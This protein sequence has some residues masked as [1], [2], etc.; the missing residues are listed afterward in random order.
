MAKG[1]SRRRFMKTVMAG[2]GAVLLAPTRRAFPA[3]G[4]KT[5]MT[6]A[7]PFG[8]TSLAFQEDLAKRFMERQKS[9]EIEVQIIPQV[10]AVPKL[11]AAFA[12]GAAP[13]CL[14][15]S[16][17]WLTQLAPPGYFESLEPQLK[18]SGLDRDI[19][20][21]GRVFVT[22]YVFDKEMIYAKRLLNPVQLE[23][24]ER[25]YRPFAQKV[26]TPAVVV[27]LQD[28]PA[29]CLDRIHRRSRPYEQEIALEFLEALDEDYRRMFAGWK[30]CPVIRIP[31]SRLTGYADAVVEHMVLQVKA[32][33]ATEAESSRGV[34]P[35]PAL[36]R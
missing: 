14:A 20:P 25:I 26:A 24:Y 33:I 18:A 5:K 12:G 13:D 8:T 31:S 32:Y 16:H 3:A 7:W 6:F 4:G 28:S 1:L 21:P 9:I 29:N 17:Q 15:L 34:G 19:L 36:S 30:A 10:Q 22:D 35:W 27:Y 23:L 11:T 2:T